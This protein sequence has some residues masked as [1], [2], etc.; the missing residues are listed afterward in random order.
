MSLHR[1]GQPPI[2]S[3]TH[4]VFELAKLRNNSLLA[5]LHN[6]ESCAKPYQNRNTS[7]KPYTHP[8]IFHVGLKAV[9]TIRWATATTILAAKE[10]G[11]FAIEITPKLVQIRRLTT[12]L[13][14]APS[15][16]S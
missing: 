2:K 5:F 16:V 1:V 8:C 10:S 15:T 12:R 6:E 13:G 14:V 3:G 11:Q 4:R 9:A 7:D